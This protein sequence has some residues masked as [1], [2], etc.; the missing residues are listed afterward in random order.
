MVNKTAKKKGKAVKSTARKSKRSGRSKKR[1]SASLQG[2]Y[3]ARIK[4]VGVG[5]GGGNVISRMRDRIGIRGI[6]YIAVNT[7]AQDLEYCN[8]R[9][10]ICI[11]KNL[12]RGLGAG[13]NPEV[14]RQAAEENRSEIVEA[15]RGADLVFIAAGYGGGT[16]SSASPIVAE[17][18]KEVGALTVAIVTKPFT[19]EGVQRMKIAEEW[20]GQ[21]KGKVDSLI[22]IPNDRIFNLIKKETPLLKA[23]EAIDDV[24][25]EAV[26]GIAE[27]IAMPG[28]INVDFSDVKGIMQDAGPSHIGVGFASGNDRAINAINQAIN[29]PL[30]DISIEGAKGVL[31]GFAGGRDLKMT[32]INEA[33]KVV[34]GSIDPSARVVFGAYLDRK[35]KQGQI[36][37]TLL[38]TGFDGQLFK[39]AESS[40]SLF[41]GSLYDTD[42]E[43]APPPR[44]SSLGT[45]ESHERQPSSAADDDQWEV[46]AFLR[47]RKKN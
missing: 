16:G 13:M 27:L 10:K 15:L 28:I 11:G 41:N 43:D 45:S 37:I 2:D 25:R 33:A 14:G 23:F 32:E 24:L 36:K 21:L 20:L 22:V 46:P 42:S 29:S 40:T 35:L 6:D 26:Q 3:S 34:A 9:Q 4:V 8:A 5:G 44:S 19:F 7:D 47:K 31:L 17:A 12:T 18:A 39:E 38:A 30:L 1:A